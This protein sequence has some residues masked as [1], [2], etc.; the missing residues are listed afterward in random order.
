MGLNEADEEL[1][2]KGTRETLF[3]IGADALEDDAGGHLTLEGR[4][5]G[6][7]E[8]LGLREVSERGPWD[9]VPAGDTTVK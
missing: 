2:T 8:E 3:A 4:D 5:L 6:G 9:G 7:G 1:N